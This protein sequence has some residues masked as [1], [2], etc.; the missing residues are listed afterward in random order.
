MIWQVIWMTVFSLG[1]SY[2]KRKQF[3]V[4]KKEMEGIPINVVIDGANVG[5]ANAN[6]KANRSNVYLN[7]G[8]IDVVVKELQ[9]LNLKPF[10]IL[11]YYHIKHL[12]KTN[13]PQIDILEV[14]ITD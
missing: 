2:N 10:V 1:T 3:D 12:L 4:F 9:D 8:N 5:F 7:A 13:Q 11:H 6:S 14:S